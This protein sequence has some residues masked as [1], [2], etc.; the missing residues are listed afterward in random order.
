MNVLN[1]DNIT[2]VEAQNLN[3]LKGLL[4][5]QHLLKN[6]VKD[7]IC[8]ADLIFARMPSTTSNLILSIALKYKKDYLVEVGGCAWDSHWN[9]G[10]RGK[11][12]AVYMFQQEKKYVK[13]AKFATYV[14]RY[15]LQNRYPNKNY[16]INCSNVYLKESNI[17]V[18]SNRI[19]KIQEMDMS[20]VILGQSVNSIDVKYKGGYLVL[21]SLKKLKELGISFIF[22]IVGPGEGVFL[23]KE[24][25]RL[26][27]ENQ[28]KII[29]SLTKEEM[30]QWYQSIDIYIQPSMQ[31]G[32]PR[33]MIEAMSLGCPAIG[34]N[35]GGI[36]EL[37]DKQQI[38]NPK[39]IKE[40]TDVIT[41]ILDKNLLIKLASDN[42]KKAKEYE[43]TKIEN[44][45][46]KIFDKYKQ[47]ILDK[48]GMQLK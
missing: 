21:R 47:Y 1:T 44:N 33:A 25:K 6:K 29:G 18:L 36:P 39:I 31:E 24:A 40:I 15:F 10:I 45:R 2:V 38:F 23:K 11:I 13:R 27:I 46:N 4:I 41:S 7:Y 19:K 8:D 43:I 37:L 26:G 30:I 14:T 20:K 42:F 16:Q 5:G 32:L 34:S 22:Q 12:M 17:K 3:T 9:H 28:L 48:R 35:V